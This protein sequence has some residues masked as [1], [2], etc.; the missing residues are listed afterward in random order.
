MSTAL[1]IA[2]VALALLALASIAGR[3]VART[4]QRGPWPACRLSCPECGQGFDA[5]QAP[6]GGC[7]W[8]GSRYA[9]RESSRR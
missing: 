4:V 1:T 9:T 5:A 7:P 3:A 2:A 8:C 6:T